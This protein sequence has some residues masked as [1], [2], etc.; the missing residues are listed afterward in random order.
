MKVN[1]AKLQ[2]YGVDQTRPVSANRSVKPAEFTQLTRARFAE[3][4]SDKE[5]TFIVQNFKPESTQEE[6]TSHLGR[7]ID[8]TA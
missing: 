6:K 7:F 1:E 4:L 8:V 5:K 2:V 3:L